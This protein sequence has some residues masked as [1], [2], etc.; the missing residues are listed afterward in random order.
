MLQIGD[1][2]GANWCARWRELAVHTLQFSE[3]RLDEVHLS[4]LEHASTCNT[5]GKKEERKD[6]K[7]GAGA[8]GPKV[9]EI[10]WYITN[11]PSPHAASASVAGADRMGPGRTTCPQR[12]EEKGTREANTRNK[13]HK[14]EHHKKHAATMMRGRRTPSPGTRSA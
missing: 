2:S 12:E 6:G 10:S 7:E 5:R 3:E 14:E 8:P 1:P 13:K 4:V 9:A 11:P